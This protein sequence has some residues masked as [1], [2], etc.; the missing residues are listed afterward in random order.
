MLAFCTL[1]LHFGAVFIKSNPKT[2]T[3]KLTTLLGISTRTVKNVIKFLV[4][5]KI[6]KRING[7]RYGYWKI[8]NKT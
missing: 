2:N 8:L 5:N 7:K 6:I 1:G 4:D 3:E